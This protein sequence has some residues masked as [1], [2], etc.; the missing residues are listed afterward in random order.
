MERLDNFNEDKSYILAKKRVDELKGYY[1]HLAIYIIV[2]IVIFSFK[3]Y[4]NMQ[5]GDTL[6]EALT[7][8]STYLTAFFWG[9][10]LLSHTF[11]TFGLNFILG[12]NWQQKKI[13]EYMNRK[14]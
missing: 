3:I 1:I 12:S 13:D 8:Y 14:I 11:K 10:G 2:N 7:S 9:I 6:Y 4:D 5:S